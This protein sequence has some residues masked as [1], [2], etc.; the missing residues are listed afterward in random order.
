MDIQRI[1]SIY[2]AVVIILAVVGFLGFS[3]YCVF[4]FLWVTVKS[5]NLGSIILG[6]IFFTF[7]VA[8]ITK[9]LSKEI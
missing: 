7:L 8:L 9:L 3:L 5:G 2:L 6:I 1:A 4:H